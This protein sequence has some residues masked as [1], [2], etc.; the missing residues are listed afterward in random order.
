M[1]HIRKFREEK[2]WTQR[3][4]AEI[5][6][7]TTD[8][9]SKLERGQRRLSQ[10]W[11][12]RIAAALGTTAAALI[13]GEPRIPVL[14]EITGS[15]TVAL[16]KGPHAKTHIPAP[17][18]IPSIHTLAALEVMDDGLLPLCGKG[19]HLCYRKPDAQ[20]H[21]ETMRGLSVV[22]LDDGQVLLR[23]VRNGQAPGTY[24]LHS[25]NAPPLADRKA[26]WVGRIAALIP[27]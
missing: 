7:V 1:N 5:I 24:T 23:E 13:G 12:E 11:M 6:G 18:G 10:H 22:M 17:P 3:Q 14:G 25:H 9:V 27:A 19:W 21:Q 16:R 2:G 4:L 8:Q 26:R 20:T 15:G